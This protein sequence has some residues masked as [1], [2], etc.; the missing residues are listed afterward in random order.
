MDEAMPGPLPHELPK[1]SRR[2]FQFSVRTM[3]LL[4][5]VIGSVLGWVAFERL[6]SAK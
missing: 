5:V 1:L 2:W 3:L 4:M 6:K